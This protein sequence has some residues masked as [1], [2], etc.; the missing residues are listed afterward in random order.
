MMSRELLLLTKEKYDMLLKS[1]SKEE[2]KSLTPPT[3]DVRHER[4]TKKIQ[5]GFVFIVKMKT[6]GPPPGFSVQKTMQKKKTSRKWLK[7]KLLVYDLKNRNKHISSY[8]FQI[9]YLRYN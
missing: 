3:P 6:K 9:G 8:T 4:T 2:E 7:L 5:Q 1:S